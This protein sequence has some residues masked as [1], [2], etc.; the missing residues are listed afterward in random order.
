MFVTVYFRRFDWFLLKYISRSLCFFIYYKFF[1][2]FA[3]Y[4][5]TLVVGSSN[6]K[7]PMSC[8]SLSLFSLFLAL[9]TLSVF[10][11]E[12]RHVEIRLVPSVMINCPWIPIYSAARWL[13]RIPRTSERTKERV[14]RRRTR[15]IV[16]FRTALSGGRRKLLPP[17]VNTPTRSPVSEGNDKRILMAFKKFKNNRY[18]ILI[19]V[20]EFV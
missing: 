6:V 9:F 5:H 17:V 19:Q 8:S 11:C 7:R 16:K 20:S 15:G 18:W 4:F 1:A 3:L 13:P 12:P 2:F 14:A 10:L